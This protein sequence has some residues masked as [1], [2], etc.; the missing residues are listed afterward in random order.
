MEAAAHPWP[1]LGA[2]LLRDGA[3]TVEQLQVALEEKRTS[4]KRLGEILVDRGF[5]T[6]TQVSR[7][8]AEQHELPFVDLVRDPVDMAAAGLLSEELARRYGAIPVRFLAD[9]SVL[10]AV[11]DPTDVV[12]SDDLRLALGTTVR[13]GVASAETIARTIARVHGGELEVEEPEIPE[14]DE[15]GG[16]TVVDLRDASSLAPAIKQVNVVLSRALDLGA[17]D[18]HFTPQR[19]RLLVRAR[20][21]GVMREIGSIPKNLQP[22]VTSRLKVMAELDIAEKRAPQDGRLSLK[23]GDRSIDVRVAVLPTSFG[24]KV[25]LRIMASGDAA[26]SLSELGLTDAAAAELERAVQQPFGAVIA[27]GPTG[28]GK[29]TTLH[30]ALARVNDDERVITTIEDPVEY[31][32]ANADQIEVNPRAGLTFASGLRTILRSDP[33]VILVGEIRD[34]ETAEIAFQAAMTGHMVLSSLHA[35]NAASAIARLKDMGVDPGLIATSLNCIVAQ[36]LARKLCEHCREPYVADQAERAE[37]GLGSA[38]EQAWLYRSTGCEACSYTGYSGRV[39]LFEVMPIRGRIRSL[40]ERSTEEIFA[41]AVEGGM[42]TMRQ[43][44]LRLVLAGVTSLAEVRRVTGD[45][46]T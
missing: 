20:V 23:S 34:E 32:V 45:R 27:V 11:A 33:D 4:T 14:P 1:A 6:P 43:D 29:S 35:Q 9:G 21:D 13:V 5:V 19:K 40:V 17:S 18:V 28:S 8:L 3:L 39:G 10:V 41:A 44:G 22:A 38:D 30:A 25:T 2:L 12:V 46:T 7:V 24:E 37:L 16:A 31:Q 26:A 15:E 36:R 42:T